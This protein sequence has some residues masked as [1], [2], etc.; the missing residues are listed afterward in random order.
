VIRRTLRLNVFTIALVAAL[1]VVSIMTQGFLGPTL[2]QKLVVGTG[3]TQIVEFDRWWTPLTSVFVTDAGFELVFVIV[4][5][6]ALVG[7]AERLL[8][9]WRTLLAFVV[10]AVGGVAVG[11]A[12][13]AIGSLAGELWSLR[14][15]DFIS[16]DPMT[17]I[18]GVAM[19]ATAFAARLWRRRMRVLLLATVLVFLLYSGQPSDLYRLCGALAGLGLGY[20]LRPSDGTPFWP[21]S[22]H[23]ETRVLLSAVIAITAL[24]P[25][26]TLLSKPRLGPLA[27]LGLL[28]GNARPIPG[29]LLDRCIDLQASSNCLRGIN[30]ERISGVGPVLLTLL[31][32]VALLV[33]ALGIS[34]G[35][36]FGAWL[37]IVVNLAMAALAALFYG[38]VPLFPE[39]SSTAALARMR[40]ELP[41]DLTI[42]TLFPLAI[43]IVVFANMRH[44]TIRSSGRV[45]R[46]YLLGVTGSLVLLSA[47]YV[48]VGFALRNQFRPRV[49]VVD[50][51]SDLPDRFAPVG[52]LAIEPLAFRPASMPVGILYDWVGPAFW[53]IV[54]LGA[55]AI[56]IRP[57]PR[58]FA[59]RA[60]ALELLRTGGGGSLS[61][62]GTWEGNH[63][64]FSPDG[65]A[66]VAYRVVNRIA[67]TTSEPFGNRQSA[68]AAVAQFARYCDDNGW[69]PFYYGLHP[70]FAGACQEMGWPVAIV[71]DETIVYPA[72]W[73]TTGK[74]WQDVRSS[75]NRAERDGVRAI[76]TLFSELT[77]R[78]VSQI[79]EIS[80][81][82]VADRG[83]PEMGFTLGGIDE[84]RDDEV[85][86]M[87]AVDSHDQIVGITSWLPSYT[88]GETTGW[89]LDFMRRVPDGPNGVM[90]FLIARAAEQFRADGIQFLSLSTAP[91]T[92]NNS[93]ELE[94][95]GIARMLRYIGAG[96]E[97][98]YG[99][100]SLFNF[101][102]KFQPEF[103]PV[104][105]AYPDSLALPTIGIALARAYVPSMSPSQAVRLMR[106]LAR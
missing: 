74:Q 41:L 6:I 103:Q 91:L 77:P 104:Y 38:L 27:P 60:R 18:T 53:L 68:L 96:L 87:I 12:A 65:Q 25:A 4:S 56:T 14:V 45:V 51:L 36:S 46:L 66:A 7:I 1:V 83:L 82:W 40:W 64:W 70:E 76:W 50:L 8:G 85:R 32:L 42:C 47:L 16:L 93:G 59:G 92:R 26:V 35:R 2:A 37:A 80:E 101:K 19:T 39:G 34:R 13:Q 79:E 29:G 23:N 73:N 55:L 97:P 106:S 88:A 52:F 58:T 15:A 10:S 105:M 33:A 99:F 31:P 98:V 9:S 28:I 72:E 57:S 86:L 30:L 54:V 22:S 11:V 49:N 44:F 62:W 94:N 24:G 95:T 48:G 5:A 90:E 84:L 102:R 43:A 20:V 100:R 67:I 71:G 17:A 75:I 69:V 21:R 89:T 3:Y 61:Y 81:L 63:Y 78:H